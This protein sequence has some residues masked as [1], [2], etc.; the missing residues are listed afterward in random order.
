MKNWAASLRPYY[1]NGAVGLTANAE[2]QIHDRAVIPLK[3][4]NQVK[5]L[6]ADEN[7]ERSAIYAE[8]ARAN[9]HPE[10]K[11]EIRATFARIWVEEVA[12]GT[13]YQAADGSW[14][15]K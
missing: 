5:K 3:S 2:V 4:R 15:Q 9:D 7:R 11:V 8:I 1:E 13:W 14:T 10:W 6:V 12:A